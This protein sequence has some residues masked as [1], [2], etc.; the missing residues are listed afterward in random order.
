MA[1]SCEVGGCAGA[2]GKGSR[3]RAEKGAGRAGGE[4]PCTIV[5]IKVKVHVCGWIG[6]WGRVICHTV[7]GWRGGRDLIV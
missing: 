3:Q 5:S 2:G 4:G 7:C 6:S 1:A